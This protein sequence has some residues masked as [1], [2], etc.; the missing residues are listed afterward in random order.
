MAADKPGQMLLFRVRP[1]PDTRSVN[2]DAPSTDLR[3]RLGPACGRRRD[4]APRTQAKHLDDNAG[5][6]QHRAERSG[7]FS[8]V[9]TRVTR[10]G[11]GGGCTAPEISLQTLTA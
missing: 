7:N 11:F 1:C 9:I 4:S 5:H 3:R 6:S 8:P 10:W 2:N